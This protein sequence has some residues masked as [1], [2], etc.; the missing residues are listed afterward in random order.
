MWLPILLI[1]L[2]VGLLLAS[3]ICPYVQSPKVRIINGKITFNQLY[4]DLWISTPLAMGS[5]YTL[6]ILAVRIANKTQGVPTHPS[7][8]NFGGVVTISNI[9][10]TLSPSIVNYLQ[11]PTIIGKN[12]NISLI[13][14]VQILT[15]LDMY[16][17][18]NITV[19]G[20]VLNE[21]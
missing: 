6:C 13:I 7:F 18:K 15:S 19:M 10:I 8:F 11:D 1:I 21:G 4:L 20:Q 3:Y 16:V 12:V 5:H 9:N 14:K 2:V 17:Y